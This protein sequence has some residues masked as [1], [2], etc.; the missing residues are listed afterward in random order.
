MKLTKKIGVLL[1]AGFLVIFGLSLA[2]KLTFEGMN[3][4]LGILAIA[5]GVML[6]LDQ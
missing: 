6:A 3:I 5:A 1:L 4:I 2:L